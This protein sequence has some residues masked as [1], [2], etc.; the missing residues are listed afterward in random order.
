MKLKFKRKASRAIFALLLI[1]LIIRLLP[2]FAPIHA[3]DIAQN[4]FAMQFSDRHDLPLGTLLTRDQENTSIVALNQ[5]SPHFINAVLA[6]EDSNFYHHGA[7][8]IKATV[9]AITQAI[10][11]R[12]FRSGASTITMQLA[13]ML[14]PA[15]RNLFSKIQ[16]IFVAWRLTAGMSKD[17]IFTAYINRLPMGGNIYGVEAAAQTYFSIP[18][19][20]LNLAQ[21]SIL[22]AIPNN[23]TYFDPYQHW[24]RLQQRQKY[25][26]SQMIKQGYIS[27]SIAD[28]TYQ[29]KVIFTSHPPGIIAAPHFLFWLASQSTSTGKPISSVIRTTIDRPLQQ[30]VQTQVQ[31]VISALAGNNVH[32]AACGGN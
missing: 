10:Q 12:K 17:D 22:A 1:F 8:E 25:V 21:A 4:Q 7:V 18:A 23:P 30:F 14:K 16:E 28:R 31:Q 24:E 19:R 6:A 11:A 29:E 5:V 32:D 27:K 13:R 26:L 20:D 15:P 9:R 3:K 2:N